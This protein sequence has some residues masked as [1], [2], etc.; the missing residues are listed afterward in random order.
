VYRSRTVAIDT[1]GQKILINGGVVFR[2]EV[3]VPAA[4]ERDHDDAELDE[5]VYVEVDLFFNRDEQYVMKKI[6][7]QIE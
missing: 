1:Q 6:K 4:I 7:S 3:D 5:S 2:I